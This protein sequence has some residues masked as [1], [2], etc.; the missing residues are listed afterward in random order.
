MT[1]GIGGSFTATGDGGDEVAG[2]GARRAVPATRFIRP[3]PDGEALRAWFAGR[4]SCGLA[5]RGPAVAAAGVRAERAD[6]P[7]DDPEPVSAQATG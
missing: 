5:R 3:T 7:D 1:T 6:G 4:I 2:L